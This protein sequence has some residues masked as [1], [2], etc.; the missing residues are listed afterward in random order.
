VQEDCQ[1]CKTSDQ[2]ALASSL[3]LSVFGAPC[4]RC[5]SGSDQV[6]MSRVVLCT[7]RTERNM[8]LNRTVIYYVA[9]RRN[10]VC[11]RGPLRC[12]LT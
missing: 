11:C 7:S 12:I 1:Q 10:S 8:R 6:V 5:L 3:M 4:K 9:K 2:S